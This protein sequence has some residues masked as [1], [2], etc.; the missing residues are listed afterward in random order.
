MAAK[1][2]ARAV[3]AETEHRVAASVIGKGCDVMRDVS[4]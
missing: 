2:W 4:P 1:D 3:V